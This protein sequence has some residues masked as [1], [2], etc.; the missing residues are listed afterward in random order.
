MFL[1]QA[2]RFLLPVVHEAPQVSALHRVAPLQ[3]RDHQ[4]PGGGAAVRSP[5]PLLLL[6]AGLHRQENL[7]RIVLLS[8]VTDVSVGVMAVVTSSGDGSDVRIAAL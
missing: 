3:S 7:Q 2:A 6:H 5:A 8:A 1:L 4:S